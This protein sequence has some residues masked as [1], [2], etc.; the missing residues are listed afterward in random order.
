[1]PLNSLSHNFEIVHKLNFSPYSSHNYLYIYFHL[2][3]AQ[4]LRSD[5]CVFLAW[6]F[7]YY[8]LPPCAYWTAHINTTMWLFKFFCLLTQIFP[9]FGQEAKFQLGKC[10]LLA[11]ASLIFPY[12]LDTGNGLTGSCPW[13][14]WKSVFLY[15]RC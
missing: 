15:S 8:F 1:M 4:R 2:I 10:F 14:L 12:L 11:L 9:K 13:S 6:W 3:L 5:T 7:I